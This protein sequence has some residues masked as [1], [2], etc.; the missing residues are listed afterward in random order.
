MAFSVL[1]IFSLDCTIISVLGMMVVQP[2]PVQGLLLVQDVEIDPVFVCQFGRHLKSYFVDG[3]FDQIPHMPS[4]VRH[5][6][7]VLP[8][9]VQPY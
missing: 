7:S 8:A 1:C 4:I 9:E 2:L 5:R 3:V 6:S